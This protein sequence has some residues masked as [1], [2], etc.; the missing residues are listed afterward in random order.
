MSLFLSFDKIFQKK[1]DSVSFYIDITY[2][3]PLNLTASATLKI[4]IVYAASLMNNSF[5]IVYR[6]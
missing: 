1:G 3:Q 4:A 2:I 5:L 6:L